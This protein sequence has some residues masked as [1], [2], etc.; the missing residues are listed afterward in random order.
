MTR[1]CK[2]CEVEKED[3]CFQYGKVM[4]TECR[5]CH[6]EWRR[7]A[8][9]KYKEKAA[10]LKKTCTDCKTEKPGS[11]FAYSLLICKECKSERELIKRWSEIISKMYIYLRKISYKYFN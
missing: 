4:R 1:V 9:K 8:A 10:T 11:A 5:D 7:E 2:K 6:N 3:E